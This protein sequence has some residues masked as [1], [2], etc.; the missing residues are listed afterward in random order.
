MKYGIVFS[1][2]A[3]LFGVAA[4]RYSGWMLLLFWPAISFSAVAAG[5]F[6]FGP[7]IYGKS[8]NGRL[9]LINQVLLLPFL[10]MLWAV[11][12]AVR[13]FRREH[14]YNQITDK[15]FIGRR[16]LSFEL[17]SF[18]D[19]VIDLTCEFNEPR[20]LRDSSYRSFPILDG[21]A[22]ST[23]ELSTWAECV[24]DLSGN[25]YIHCAE[26]HG[27]SG[28]F[29]AVLLLYAGDVHTVDEAVQLIQSKRPRVRLGGT[30]LKSLHS[31]ANSIGEQ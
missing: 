16:L 17:P 23:T 18:I 5:Y 12:Y 8:S 21:F 3:V 31:F 2:I 19:H 25:I 29:A 24:A 14:A 7:R 11:W 20:S 13:L 15:V 6:Y 27:R 1:I 26:G 4:V 10:L 22:P 28:L 9:A 30:Q